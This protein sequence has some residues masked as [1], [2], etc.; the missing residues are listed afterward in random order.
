MAGP[1]RGPIRTHLHSKGVEVD[2]RRLCSRRTR[3]RHCIESTP[4][5]VAVVKGRGY[6]TRNRINKSQRAMKPIV[7]YRNIVT[8]LSGI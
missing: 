5:E 1:D 8:V 3:P 4:G 7:L 2:T 6:E